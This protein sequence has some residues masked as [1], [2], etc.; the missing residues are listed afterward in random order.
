MQIVGRTL[1]LPATAK[2]RA[3]VAINKQ[4]P[5]APL[6]RAVLRGYRE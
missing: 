2:S 3:A 5:S 4:N 1:A 6:R